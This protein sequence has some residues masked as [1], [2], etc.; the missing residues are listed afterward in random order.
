[1]KF[2]ELA[3]P[4][5][6]AFE[7]SPSGMAFVTPDWR[8]VKVNRAICNMLGR[9]EQELTSRSANDFTHPD[10]HHLVMDGLERLLRGEIAEHQVEARYLHSDGHV[11][12]SSVHYGVLRDATG[13]VALIIAAS[14]DITP[15]R[16]M[17]EIHDRLLGLVLVGQGVQALAE[18]LADLIQSPVALLDGHGQPLAESAR[19]G[20][21]VIPTRTELEAHEQGRPSPGLTIHPL[22]V[23]AEVEGYLI[24]ADRPGA[25]E[26]TAMAIEQAASSFAL[27]L[28]MTRTAEEVE[29][30]LHGDLFD[31][32]LS[33]R[34]PDPASIMRWAQ[35]LGHDLSTFRFLAF[36]RPIAADGADLSR[37]LARLARIGASV[38]QGSAPGSI[39]V[40]RPDGV[41]VALTA[42]ATELARAI[43]ARL[44]E[45]T[46]LLSELQIVV[47]LSA[48]IAQVSDIGEAF[49]Q[50]SQAAD[51]AVALPRLGP[52]TS[53]DDLDLQHLLLSQKAPDELVRAAR[54]TLAPLM[55]VPDPG[56]R[57][58]L[59]ATLAAYL[60]SLCTLETTA[61]RLGIHVNTLRYRLGQIESALDVP[62]ADARN[63]V[64]LQIALDVLEL[65]G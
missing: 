25:G 48:E 26:V 34:P 1:L 12:W 51:A 36:I 38:A 13:E 10:D 37:P 50:A 28:A 3:E 64:T 56:R 41:L 20:T 52:V 16:Q 54:R 53:P 24:A 19:H 23:G 43:L 29:H 62:L 22:E 42:P 8:F 11:G 47:G 65:N 55:D 6:I 57:D 18:T 59:L 44:V 45:R 7:A 49:R 46:A 63:R 60:E 21:L 58:R 32:M 5:R 9:S 35:R 31:A 27:Q 33:E 40:P 2:E 17:R 4:Y 15:Q 14:E 39:A 61:Q 30:R